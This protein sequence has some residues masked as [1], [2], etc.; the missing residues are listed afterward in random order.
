MSA[1]PRPWSRTPTPQHDGTT[2]LSMVLLLPPDNTVTGAVG[3]AEVYAPK[4]ETAEA[5][6]DL[7][8][9]AVNSHD[10]LIAMVDQLDGYLRAIRSEDLDG[11]EPNL[12]ELL[13]KSHDL[14][15]KVTP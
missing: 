14:L 9:K 5:N 3:L 7:I 10:D 13:E 11:S 8:V 2:G 6:A 4:V 12:G 15:A 1:T